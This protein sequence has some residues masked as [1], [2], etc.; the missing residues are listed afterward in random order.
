VNEPDFVFVS[1]DRLLDIQPY[2]VSYLRY[3]FC[4]FTPGTSTLK[5]CEYVR[6]G[7]PAPPS[8]PPGDGT[9]TPPADPDADGDGVPASADCRDDLAGV[10]PGGV[11]VPGNGL[12]DDCA[13]GDRPA[14]I[15]AAVTNDWLVIGART[16]V[17]ELR[18][19]RA[20]RN[21]RVQVRCTGKRC[22]FRTRRAAVRPSGS[23][24]LARF[25][26]KP[27]R[28]GTTIEVRITAPYSIGKVVRY[29]IRDGALPADKTRCLRPGATKP[30]RRC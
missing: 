11:E 14:R 6:I 16:R 9:P 2:Q 13:G 12:D 18:V 17:R 1:Y 19:R 5:D 4:H 21:A 25:F 8:P 15:T 24:K 7:R 29:R 20:P 23:A 3:D 22:P 28:P 10:W 27:L 26:R 30:R